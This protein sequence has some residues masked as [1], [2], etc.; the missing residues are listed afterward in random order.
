MQVFY[1]AQRK[2]KVWLA[3]AHEDAQR[4]RDHI[5]LHCGRLQ[6]PR[7]SNRPKA[8]PGLGLPHS[9]QHGG[10][11]EES[12]PCT[13][14][15]EVAIWWAYRAWESN[16][17]RQRG[18]CEGVTELADRSVCDKALAAGGDIWMQRT[19][20]AASGFPPYLALADM[21]GPDQAALPE[22]EAILPSLPPLEEDDMR[23][24]EV[25]ARQRGRALHQVRQYVAV[26]ARMQ[27]DLTP[28]VRTHMIKDLGWHLGPAHETGEVACGENEP[29]PA[30]LLNRT[31]WIMNKLAT[32]R[33]QKQKA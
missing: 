30:W 18:L 7:G 9:C 14:Q 23:L 2:A 6:R 11:L 24:E 3:K 15:A 12:R 19:P 21:E 25:I 33:D 16:L 22:E 29:E 8:V 27:R 13:L 4:A 17:S 5:G 32:I 20:E 10:P 28:S 26:L 1:R 31:G